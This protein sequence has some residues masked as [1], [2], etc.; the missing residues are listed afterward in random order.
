MPSSRR[1]CFAAASIS[2]A[3][4]IM[5]RPSDGSSGL[6]DQAQH[7]LETNEPFEGRPVVG[8]ASL[9]LGRDGQVT[10]NRTR[11]ATLGS[12][13]V[14]LGLWQR[15]C[16]VLAVGRQSFALARQALP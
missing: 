1:S 13:S 8:R 7:P 10:T 16:L 2:S 3:V 6:P 5:S 4:N 14:N 15:W 9:D 11:C 12:N